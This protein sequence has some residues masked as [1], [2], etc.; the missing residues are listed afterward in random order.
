MGSPMPKF[1]KIFY[2][3]PDP[4]APNA[5]HE[6]LDIL[7]IAL[8]A[9]LCGAKCATDMELF[10]L[11]K[12]PLLRQFLRLEHGIPSHDTFSRV[13]RALDPEAFERAFRRFIAAFAKANGIKLT[14]VV[15][16]D[17]KAVRGA[18]ER[19]KSS[20]PL[21][22]VNV[23]A[24]EARMVLAARKAPWKYCRCCR[25]KAASLP[26]MR[27]IAAGPSPRWCSRAVRNLF[28]RSSRTRASCSTPSNDVLR[29]PANAALPAVSN[30]RPTIARNP[31]VRRSFA[32]PGWLPQITFPAWSHWVG[33]R[34]ADVATANVPTNRA[35]A[36]TCCPN[37][38]LPNDCCRLCAVIG[39]SKIACIGYSMWSSTRIAVGPEK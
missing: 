1:S 36:I 13:F 39:V 21:H 17:G 35:C 10:G 20:T 16:V 4:R 31:A 7:V 26:P 9:V 28:W 18:Y 5:L 33:S 11:A 37:T 38:C 6:L 19:G 34:R 25:S 30:R 24:A 15:A 12:E 29:A 27:C 8:A 3:L 22:M 23:F 14:G 32:T 2:G